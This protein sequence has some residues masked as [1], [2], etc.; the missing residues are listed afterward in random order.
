MSYQPAFDLELAGPVICISCSE[1][2]NKI[3]VGD[4][5][6]NLTLMNRAGEKIWEKKIDEG[7]HGLSLLKNGSNVV[8]G[9]KDCKLKMLNSLGSVE[10][11]QT[12][13]KSIWSL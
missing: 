5:N 4:R 6:G 2:G 3:A 13:G 1:D 11:E 8:C 12:I 7:V 10:W 9:G